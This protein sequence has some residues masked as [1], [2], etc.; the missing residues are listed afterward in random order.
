MNER[1]QRLFWKMVDFD[2]DAQRIQ[3]FTKV[4]AYAALIAEG[5]HMAG[6][7]RREILEAAALVHDIAI[8]LCL[9]KYGS[10]VGPLQE[11]EG[12]ALV[13]EMLPEFGYDPAFIERVAWLVGHHHTYNPIDGDDH[14]ILVEADFLVNAYEGAHSPEGNQATLKNIFKTQTGSRLFRTM[15]HVSEE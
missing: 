4:H 2:P 5:E 14:Q 8:R 11:K 7:R 1:L 12:P 15:F 9:E 10:C 13:R 6:I 3:H